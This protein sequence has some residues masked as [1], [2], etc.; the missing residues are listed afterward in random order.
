MHFQAKL[1]KG[2]ADAEDGPLMVYFLELQDHI[3]PMT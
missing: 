2:R 3:E 1:K